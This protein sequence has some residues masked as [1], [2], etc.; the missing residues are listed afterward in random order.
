MVFAKWGK[1]VEVSGWIVRYIRIENE[2]KIELFFVH[3]G[4]KVPQRA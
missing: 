1:Q 2:S 3:Q 4:K